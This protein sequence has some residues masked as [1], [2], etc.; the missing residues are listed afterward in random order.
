M[1]WEGCGPSRLVAP[2]PRA[3]PGCRGP[4]T[5]SPA[6]LDHQI[7][8]PLRNSRAHRGVCVRDTCVSFFPL[9]T[10]SFKCLCSLDAPSFVD[11]AVDTS[12]ID[13]ETFSLDLR[14]KGTVSG[15]VRCL[16]DCSEPMGP[17]HGLDQSSRALRT[18]KPPLRRA[19]TNSIPP[20]PRTHCSSS[21][22]SS[23][24]P[25]THYHQPLQ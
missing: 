12:R 19:P 10:T 3:L 5:G 21:V 6:T 4:L 13:S 20:R 11:F 8:R 7:R 14:A 24:S 2:V 16:R 23:P 9:S 15:C 22:L 1:G 25:A 17:S 18:Y